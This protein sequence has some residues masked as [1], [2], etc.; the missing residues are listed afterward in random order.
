MPATLKVT[1]AWS[2]V[3]DQCGK[4]KE[5]TKTTRKKVKGQYLPHR[6]VTTGH[7]YCSDD[8]RKAMAKKVRKVIKEHKK[9]LQNALQAVRAETQKKL[10]ELLK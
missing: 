10:K 9:N 4:T 2:L 7:T 5:T 3:C 1:Y 6:E 8:C